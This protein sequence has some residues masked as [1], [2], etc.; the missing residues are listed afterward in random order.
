[1][2]KILITTLI[3][4][5]FVTTNINGQEI[6]L[7]QNVQ[8]DTIPPQ[9]GPNLKHYS[10]LYFAYGFVFGPSQ[11]AGSAIR[12][13]N[14]TDFNV[15]YRY[16]RKISNFY[17]LGFDFAYGV[18]SFNI[19]QQQGKTLPNNVFHDN[20]KINFNHLG[21]S[22]YNRFNFGKRGNIIGNFLDIGAYGN[23]EFI[24][25]H[26]Y[27]E[28]YVSPNIANARFTRVINRQLNYT[29]PL[30]YGVQ[31]RLGFNR[32]AFYGSYRL[33]DKFKQE[34]MYPELPRFIIGLQIGL[35]G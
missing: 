3:A 35:H 11:A 2:K 19:D 18:T 25:K 34:F 12:Y 30:N 1:M 33:S 6:L 20:E 16:K 24:V 27:T 4:L 7:E 28:N 5:A 26:I 15:G 17:A 32:Y 14:S 8:G 10:H 29:N 22:L 21:V 23:W 9:R 31:A 13:G